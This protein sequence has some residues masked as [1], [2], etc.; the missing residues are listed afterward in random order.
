MK[1]HYTSRTA[2][3]WGLTEVPN[4]LPSCLSAIKTS[5]PF[6]LHFHIY[7]LD[8]VKRELGNLLCLNVSNGPQ[9]RSM[10]SWDPYEKYVCV[11]NGMAHLQPVTGGRAS[12]THLLSLAAAP[13]EMF[14]ADTL[15]FPPK[16]GRIVDLWYEKANCVGFYLVL[17]KLKSQMHLVF[18]HLFIYLFEKKKIE[19]LMLASSQIFICS[20]SVSWPSS[21]L[22]TKVLTKL[23]SHY[24]LT[25]CVFHKSFW[26]WLKM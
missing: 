22:H 13:N 11:Y 16:Q 7:T 4:C 9:H 10:C 14:A 15:P 8:E 20:V 1:V 12:G 23:R 5:I 19:I 3:I 25:H 21:G 17:C 2:N 26:M 24:K 18:T 6:L